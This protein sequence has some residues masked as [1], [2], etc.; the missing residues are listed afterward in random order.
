M[1]TTEDRQ[2]VIGII[3][4]VQAMSQREKQFYSHIINDMP[5]LK[6]IVEDMANMDQN[7]RQ[8]VER[9]DVKVK[10]L[11]PQERM[12]YKKLMKN[13]PGTAALIQN[14]AMLSPE[15]VKFYDDLQQMMREGRVNDVAAALR[16]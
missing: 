14:E 3:R 11:E 6:E 12:N 9:L 16:G 4:H 2:R 8:A 1:I 7:D 5:R 13:Y 10:A 15:A